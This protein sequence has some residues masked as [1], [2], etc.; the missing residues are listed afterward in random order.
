MFNGM[1]TSNG[2]RLAMPF[3]G[4]SFCNSRSSLVMHGELLCIATMPKRIK[5]KKKKGHFL[6]YRDVLHA[7]QNV[8]AQKF[9]ILDHLHVIICCHWSGSFFKK[10]TWYVHTEY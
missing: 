5:K 9:S 4:K 2:G 6:F 7:K 3:V 1:E 8:H 10:I